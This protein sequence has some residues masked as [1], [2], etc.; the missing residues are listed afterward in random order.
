MLTRIIKILFIK[1]RIG[2]VT[3]YKCKS[4]KRYTMILNRKPW[5]FNNSHGNKLQCSK[6]PAKPHR[7]VLKADKWVLKFKLKNTMR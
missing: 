1:S 7:T 4:M 2:Q 5:Y 3:F 6:I